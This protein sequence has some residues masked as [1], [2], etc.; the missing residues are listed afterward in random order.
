MDALLKEDDFT[1]ARP[2]G[3]QE[4]LLHYMHNVGALIATLTLHVR[5]PFDEALLKRGLAWLQQR[6]PMLRAHIQWRGFGTNPQFPW[7]HRKF[8]FDTRGTK[9]IPVRIVEGNYEKTLQREMKRMFP[10]GKGPRA[11]VTV[12]RESPDF[13]RIILTCDHSIGDGLA[14]LSAARD[15][16]GF[17]ADPDNAP[18]VNDSRLPPAL[19]D[20]FTPSSDPRRKYLPAQRLPRELV[21]GPIETRY[22][23]RLLSLAESD[24]LRAAVKQQRTTLNGAVAA[25]VLQAAGAHFDLKTLTC[26]TNP[27][28]RKLMKPPLPSD[29][30]GCYIDAVRTVHKLDQP[31]W[32]LAREVS[33]KLVNA[34]AT[35]QREV[36]A[37]TLPGL[38]WYI[39]ETIPMITS[40]WCL[41]GVSVTTVGDTGFGRTYGPFELEDITVVASL[42]PLGLGLYTVVAEFQGQVQITLCYGSNRIRGHR[43][44]D[45]A[46]RTM[47]TLRN[48]SAG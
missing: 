14:A 29:T 27:E 35:H 12:V 30:F 1:E 18:R 43:V 10:G 41:D 40:G 21:W 33:F 45:I 32:S 19:E 16:M 6:H 23:K 5:G 38:D 44:A 11:R 3:E 24:A 17:M 26:L 2:L 15:L 4:R 8:W 13:H 28:L 25:A 48:L 9:E 22:E 7:I 34:I 31:F 47:T 20:R 42:N 37:R 46:E 39:H 36:S